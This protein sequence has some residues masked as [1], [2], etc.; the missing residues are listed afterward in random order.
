MGALS[1]E[2][3]ARRR[4]QQCGDCRQKECGLWEWHKAGRRGWA[5]VAPRS[6]GWSSRGWIA[7]SLRDRERGWDGGGMQE[8]Y[9]ERLLV[10]NG[11]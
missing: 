7:H 1:G 5:E 6:R 9:L 3:H 8:V 2:G 10:A 4:E 11:L